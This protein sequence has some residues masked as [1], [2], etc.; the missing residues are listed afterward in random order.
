MHNDIIV[1][2]SLQ[3]ILNRINTSYYILKKSDG[4]I[5]D[6]FNKVIKEM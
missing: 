6:I 2:L 5:D 3:N 1:V 4:M